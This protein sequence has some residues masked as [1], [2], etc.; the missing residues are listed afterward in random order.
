MLLKR[1]TCPTQ[2]IYHTKRK[3]IKY[4][5]KQVSDHNIQSINQ[6]EAKSTAKPL[7]T[8]IQTSQTYSSMSMPHK[9]QASSLNQ[10]LHQFLG[11]EEA[12][13]QLLGL[14]EGLEVSHLPGAHGQEDGELAH[15]PPQHALV[16]ALRG[17][18]E[19]LLAVPLVVLLLGDLLH[20]IQ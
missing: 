19:A 9:D 3:K 12:L 17:L 15:A 10:R 18:P 20:L 1:L 2:I 6:T 11:L 7:Y 8:N 14:E 16:G 13:H 4:F 5:S